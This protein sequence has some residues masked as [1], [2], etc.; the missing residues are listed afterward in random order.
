MFFFQC[1]YN[2]IIAPSAE[3]LASAANT[4]ALTY[5]EHKF[6]QQ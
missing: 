4:S 3:R 6:E 1:L 2:L 5:H